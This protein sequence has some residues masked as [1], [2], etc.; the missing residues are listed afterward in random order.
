MF[1]AIHEEFLDGVKLILENEKHKNLLKSDVFRYSN[2][3]MN[4]LVFAACKNN[5]EI[6][7]VLFEVYKIQVIWNKWLSDNDSMAESKIRENSKVLKW[8]GFKIISKNLKYNNYLFI[9]QN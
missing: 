1:F 4:P 6:V 7:S 8:L 2:F 3:E 5:Y 9:F